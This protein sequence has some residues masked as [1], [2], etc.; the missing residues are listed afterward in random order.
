MNL[1]HWETGQ[2]AQVHGWGDKNWGDKN[3]EPWVCL[4][5]PEL[6]TMPKNEDRSVCYGWRRLEFWVT[7]DTPLKEKK[8]YDPESEAYHAQTNKMAKSKMAKQVRWQQE[9]GGQ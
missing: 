6:D 3:G 7:E 8:T 1:K 4:Y 5:F 2:K 9:T